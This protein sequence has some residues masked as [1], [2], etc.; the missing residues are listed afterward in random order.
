MQRIH[1]QRRDTAAADILRIDR[2]N[3]SASRIREEGRE[4]YFT[5]RGRKRIEAS[6]SQG[7]ARGAGGVGHSIPVPY[8]KP[9][10]DWRSSYSPC[11]SLAMGIL[12]DNLEVLNNDV[13]TT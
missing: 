8:E 4:G 13:A 6:I 7:K 9:W 1:H 10:S 12:A 2:P 3:D 11:V 5:V